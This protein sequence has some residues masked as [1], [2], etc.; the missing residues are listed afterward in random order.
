MTPLVTATST[1]AG[2]HASP[3]V[4][5]STPASGDQVE[6]G[7]TTDLGS[8]GNTNPSPG[9]SELSS[10][11]ILS[12]RRTSASDTAWALGSPTGVSVV[13]ADT[14]GT[15]PAEGSI[16]W[17]CDCGEA[18]PP[19]VLEP[20][21]P[22]RDERVPQPASDSPTATATTGA[23]PRR[24]LIPGSSAHGQAAARRLAIAGRSTG[25]PP[26]ACDPMSPGTT[27]GPSGPRR[28]PSRSSRTATACNTA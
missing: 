24:I 18:D 1:A 5:M 10:C 22:L 12:S 7:S 14:C 6:G 20:P 23:A 16:A 26:T 27:N 19:A 25:S 11:T 17:G 8:I 13:D 15:A 21:D 2:P 9:L 28:R 4:A 3:M